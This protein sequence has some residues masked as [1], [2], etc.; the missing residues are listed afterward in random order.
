MAYI[1]GIGVVSA[2]GHG[3]DDLRAALESGEAPARPEGFI[4]DMKRADKAELK[5]LRRADKLSKLSV[6]AAKGALRDAG[7]LPMDAGRLPDAGQNLSDGEALEAGVILCTALGP[8]P[9]TFKFLDDTIQ[10]GD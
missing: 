6:L 10:Y 7:R 3:L 1:K 2:A 9:T 8:H 4:V 5:R